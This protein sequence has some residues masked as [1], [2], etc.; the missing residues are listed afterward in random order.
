MDVARRDYLF[1]NSLMKFAIKNDRGGLL[2]KTPL[3]CL[4]ILYA[5][6]FKEGRNIKLKTC[7]RWCKTLLYCS[8]ESQHQTIHWTKLPVKGI[9]VEQFFPY[10]GSRGG[11]NYVFHVL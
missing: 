9:W 3:D 10:I 6:C 1:V 7:D 5:R 8:K 2:Q 4:R 11:R